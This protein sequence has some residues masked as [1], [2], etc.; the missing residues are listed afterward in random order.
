M[1]HESRFAFA[2]LV[3]VLLVVALALALGATEARAS[4]GG[5]S[6]M[7]GMSAEE[8]QNMATPTPA[9]TAMGGGSMSAPGDA[10]SGDLAPAMDPHMDMGG[11]S[12]NWLVIG[13]FV[14]LIV[15]S[16]LGAVAT[17]RH[18]AGRMAA[19]EL[20]GAGALDA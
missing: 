16:T 15:G 20:A 8:M 4:D 14:A 6:G 19:G 9:A 3:I 2:P 13:G 10:Q 17:K 1:P 11:G 12:V 5:M 18:L 7:P